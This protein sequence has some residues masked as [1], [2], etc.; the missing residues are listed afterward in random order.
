MALLYLGCPYS[1][2][3][4]V[5]RND[6]AELASMYAA[7]L[8]QQGHAVY[9]PI[10]H[11]HAVASHLAPAVASDHEFWMKQCLPILEISDVLVVLPLPGWRE[12]RGLK[13]EMEFCRAVNRPMIPIF[14]VQGA[15]SDLPG[16][17]LEGLTKQELQARRWQVYGG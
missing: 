11:G 8:M 4:P 14:F 1:H 12:S 13:Q 2:S 6:R 5:V 17:R 10:T 15:L 16:N 7:L 3:D 9:S